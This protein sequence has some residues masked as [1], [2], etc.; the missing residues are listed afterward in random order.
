MFREGNAMTIKRRLVLS[1]L[2]MIIVPVL[3]AAIVGGLSIEIVFEVF[4]CST[5]NRKQTPVCILQLNTG[6]INIKS[7]EIIFLIA[8]PF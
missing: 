3:I 8:L 6:G 2:M 1:N 4:D 5:I 7:Q